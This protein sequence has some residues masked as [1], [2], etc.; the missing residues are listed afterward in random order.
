MSKETCFLCKN[1][2]A[3]FD[4]IP[5]NGYIFYECPVCGC[6]AIEEDFKSDF[7]GDSRF[8]KEFELKAPGIAAELKLKKED[9]YCLGDFD[10]SKNG[11]KLIDSYILLSVNEFLAKYPKT[12]AAIFDRVLLNLSRCVSHPADEYKFESKNPGIPAENAIFYSGT[13]LQAKQTCYSLENLEYIKIDF[14]QNNPCL[15]KILPNGWARIEQ[16]ERAKAFE[17]LDKVFLAMWFSDDLKNLKSSVKKAVQNAGYDPE[18]ICVNDMPHNDFIMDKVINMINDARFVI[19]DFTSIPEYPEN[20]EVKGGVR[21]GVYFEAGYAKG[22][23]KTVIMTC[24]EDDASKD[25]RHFDI[26]QMNTLFWT[27]EDGVLKSK[28]NDFIE[29]LTS[30]ILRTVGEGPNFGKT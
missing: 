21:G 30:H 8:K 16:L 25:R 9:K 11:E 22:Q 4:V 15:I 20:N 12:G 23:G 5:K 14:P 18:G 10:N 1:P 13:Y 7:D 29:T 27:E 6:F 26:G 28:G 24:K 17:K 2:D 19:A 3:K